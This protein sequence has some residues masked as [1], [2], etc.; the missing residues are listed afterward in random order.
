MVKA[1][2]FKDVRLFSREA[3]LHYLL[4]QGA[5]GFSISNYSVAEE[6][7]QVKNEFLQEK[8]RCSS[9]LIRLDVFYSEKEAASVRNRLFPPH[10]VSS[11]E[12]SLFGDEESSNDSRT[13]DD[14]TRKQ[15]TGKPALTL[16]Q[17]SDI[18]SDIDHSSEKNHLFLT[19]TLP[20]PTT[21]LIRS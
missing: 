18:D 16:F 11:S 20:C 19:K 12:S 5:S 1:F 8:H 6:K 15:S 10:S 9:C 3:A 2:S 13:L 14:E 4:F 7:K 17:D 21:L